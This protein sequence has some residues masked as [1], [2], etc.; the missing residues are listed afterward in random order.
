M[1]LNYAEQII[2]D[3]EA[4]PGVSKGGSKK[5]PPII[6]TLQYGY[7]GTTALYK[8]QRTGISTLQMHNQYGLLDEQGLGK[9][10][11]GL[12]AMLDLQK[13]KHIDG[14]L[15]IVKAAHV[16]VWA[17][18]DDG[19]IAQHARHIQPFVISGMSPERRRKAWPHGH[20]IYIINYELLSNILCSNNKDSKKHVDKVRKSG[21][22]TYSHDDLRGVTIYGPDARNLVALLK[23]G[24]F[25]IVC[26]ECFQY[27]MPVLTDKGWMPIGKIVDEK[28]NVSVL[29]CDLSKHALQWKKITGYTKK[30]LIG[31][32]VR[33]THEYGEIVCTTTHKIWT[34]EHGYVRAKNLKPGA[35]INV[36]TESMRTVRK[37]VHTK[38][39][40]REEKV[41]RKLVCGGAENGATRTKGETTR[42]CKSCREGERGQEMPS[43]IG[44]NASEQP[45]A[46]TGNT[47]KSITGT[48]RAQTNTRSQAWGE[49]KTPN[50]S[51]KCA[52]K[53][54]RIGRVRCGVSSKDH[55]DTRPIQ[56]FTDEL[57]D[58]R[59]YPRSND[60]DRGGRYLAQSSKKESPGPEEG[61]GLTHS[62]VARVE[63]LEPGSTTTRRGNKGF[64]YCLEVEENHN[65]FADGVLVSNSHYIMNPS[66]NVTKVAWLLGKLAERR[67]IMTGTMLAERP[68]NAWSQIYFLDYGKL[69]GDYNSFMNQHAVF[70]EGRNVPGRKRGRWVV[71]YKNLKDLRKKLQ[72]ITLRR[73]TEDCIDLPEKVEHPISLVPEGGQKR[74]LDSIRSNIQMLLKNV[75]GRTINLSGDRSGLPARIQAMMRATATPWL[76]DA[77]VKESAKLEELLSLLEDSGDEQ[78]VVWT[79]HRDVCEAASEW[80]HKHNI[81][82]TFVHGGVPKGNQ[83][84]TRIKAFKDGDH[85]VLVATAHT[86][87]E[88]YTLT[89]SRYS[90][91]LDMD[92]SRLNFSQSS[93]RQHRM[94]AEKTVVLH[95]PFI[96][97]TTDEYIWGTIKVKESRVTMALDKDPAATV[98]D[99][100]EFMNVL[101]GAR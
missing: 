59:S 85:R 53:S 96:K 22:F 1:S 66:A 43:Y 50:K 33:V 45:N 84:D 51:T 82:T 42:N 48:Q 3:F 26:D 65:F 94:G 52:D 7:R 63:T 91:Y 78:F 100:R 35:H 64:V 56:E 72:T 83:R 86:M 70:A 46:P 29:S 89:N 11:Q 17:D 16:S 75:K 99:V 67:Y 6:T 2:M 14:V 12:Y 24:R 101:G 54:N 69:L 57:Q 88:S 41:L 80:L 23:S 98:I 61:Y 19:Q 90:Y 93:K 68:E 58:R 74:L 27:D 18:E 15:L 36:L 76:V 47:S 10:L 39:S 20:K 30:P 9:S 28:L 77:A 92:F 32:L 25:A 21:E 55:N 5:P 34:E 79:S 62:R 38:G 13:G 40:P 49:R 8:H 97:R 81:T 31:P 60:S 95:V 87:R 37:E 73:L 71:R 4:V 44:T